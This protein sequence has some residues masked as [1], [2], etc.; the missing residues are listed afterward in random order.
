MSAGSRTAI[1]R[2]RHSLDRREQWPDLI[3]LL[4]DEVEERPNAGR[5]SHV[6]VHQKI[7]WRSQ[8]RSEIHE[9]D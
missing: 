5:V 9:A 6:L 7:K 2:K 3:Q 8:F 4:D 1:T